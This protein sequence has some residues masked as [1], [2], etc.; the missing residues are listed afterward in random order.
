MHTSV[1]I[2][3]VSIDEVK[4]GQTRPM[5]S[6]ANARPWQGQGQGQDKGQLVHVYSYSSTAKTSVIQLI[7]N[8]QFIKLMSTCI[9]KTA[10]LL[11]Q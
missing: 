3:G 1:Q 10:L 2:A 4:A 6:E 5:P 8:L 9:G 7:H 11:P